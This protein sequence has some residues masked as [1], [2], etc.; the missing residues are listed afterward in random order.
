MKQLFMLFFVACLATCASA[1]FIPL[2]NNQLYQNFSPGRI[3]VSE[4]SRTFAVSGQSTA[5]GGFSE[6]KGSTDGGATWGTFNSS[7]IATGTNVS[8]GL[9]LYT[10]QERYCQS[11]EVTNLVQGTH[12]IREN[13]MGNPYQFVGTPFAHSGSVFSTTSQWDGTIG[14]YTTKLRRLNG[15]GEEI[16]SH[17]AGVMQIMKFSDAAHGWYIAVDDSLGPLIATQYQTSDGGASW[18]LRHDFPPFSRA[19]DAYCRISFV[20]S[21]D[22]FLTCANR[23]YATSDGGNHWIP[24]G[25]Y[26]GNICDLAFVSPQIGY[27]IRN[28]ALY[29]TSD[30]GMN[31]SWQRPVSYNLTEDFKGYLLTSCDDKAYLVSGDSVYVTASATGVNNSSILPT[32]FSLKQNYP[33]PFNPVTTITFELPRAT[34]VRLVI[35]DL[36]GREVVR[37]ADGLVEAGSHLVTFDGKPLASGTYIY[38]LETPDL[39]IIKKMTLLK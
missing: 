13:C 8:E 33:N 4:N 14:R 35:Y 29:R 5:L 39:T 3:I 7:I 26:D 16:V 24:R 19:I 31:W 10:Y 2:Q 38:R 32:S 22:G 15:Q 12:F 1:Q 37:L 30:G 20:S 23:L 28:A 27:M 9:V 11:L 34:I 17:S 36:L 18:Q 21:T 25:V 6:L